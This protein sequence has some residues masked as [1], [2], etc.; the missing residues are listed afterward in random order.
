MTREEF[1]KWMNTCPAKENGK[2]AGWFAADDEGDAV[3]IF[4]YFDLTGE[5]DG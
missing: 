4:F 2:S 5:D 3:R 1:W